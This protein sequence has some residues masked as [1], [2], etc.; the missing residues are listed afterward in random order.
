MKAMITF[1]GVELQTE[2]DYQPEEKPVMYY[3]DGSG[4]PGCSEQI[5]NITVYHGDEDITDLCEEVI[6]LIE[7]RIYD[8]MRERDDD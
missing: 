2:F 7:E 1:R 6:K 3:R 5:D 8:S 4:Y